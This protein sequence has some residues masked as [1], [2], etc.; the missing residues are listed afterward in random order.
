M[1]GVAMPDFL[2]FLLKFVVN[3]LPKIIKQNLT[4]AIVT[5]SLSTIIIQWI[6]IGPLGSNW[7]RNRYVSSLLTNSDNAQS[8]LKYVQEDEA[9]KAIF[10]QGAQ[11]SGVFVK[12]D[13]SLVNDWIEDVSSV[14]YRDEAEKAG[15]QTALQLA[16]E[17][18]AYSMAPFQPVGMVLAS[19][20]PDCVD[21]R[22]AFQHVFIANN[23]PEL[24]QWSDGMKVK[25]VGENGRKNEVVAIVSR[26]TFDMNKSV[27]VH[28]NR[29]QREML[30]QHGPIDRVYLSPTNKSPFQDKPDLIQSRP[31]LNCPN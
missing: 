23:R 25:I 5:V 20:S 7:L 1:R 9:R 28:L 18:A 17:K 13:K 21:E 4:R 24:R 16:R 22:P 19:S 12:T 8:Y 2:I 27:S 6:I 14:S 31:H 26:L 29:S 15:E 3:D 30:G 11:Q 10:F